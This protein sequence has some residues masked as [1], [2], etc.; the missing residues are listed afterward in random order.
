MLSDDEDKSSIAICIDH[1][2]SHTFAFENAF[3]EEEFK[4]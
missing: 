3:S 2:T 4:L 1:T